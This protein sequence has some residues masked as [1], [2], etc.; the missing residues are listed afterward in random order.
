ML[1][2][3]ALAL[4]PT[5]RAELL[6][7]VGGDFTGAKRTSQDEQ[8]EVALLTAMGSYDQAEK[9][10]S[11]LSA[12][13]ESAS[14]FTQLGA[15]QILAG[16][17]DDAD[18]SY[19]KAVA[20]NPKSGDAALGQADVLGRRGHYDEAA[21]R[22]AG[23]AALFGKANNKIGLRRVALGRAALLR[24]QAAALDPAAA[25]A[26]YQNSLATDAKAM[27]T[28]LDLALL[29]QKRGQ[30][31]Q[32]WSVMAKGIELNHADHDSLQAAL[33]FATQAGDDAKVAE[34]TQRLGGRS[35]VAVVQ[36]NE[37]QR[38]EAE[39]KQA[40]RASAQ[41]FYEDLASPAVARPR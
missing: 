9:L 39:V 12:G 3:R 14:S 24:A 25:T 30:A 31:E 5:R 38:V 6:K 33:D 17:L 2:D 27:S 22:Y 20:L 8:V 40:Q 16:R 29:L 19:S 32:A 15:I 1:I 26:L 37:Q 11:Q 21:A 4:A 10:L 35:H 36:V 28:R 34:L 13:R 7:A 18:A 41:R 23:A